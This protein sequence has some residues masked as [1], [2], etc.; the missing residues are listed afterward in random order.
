ME[1]L[2]CID[3]L[4]GFGIPAPKNLTWM[5]AFAIE[6]VVSLDGIY[7]DFSI[8]TK[9]KNDTACK[10]VAFTQTC[11]LHQGLVEYSI[12]LTNN[13]ISLRYPH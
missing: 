2:T 12:I 3:E 4:G 11:K 6:P 1:N 5:T 10:G 7:A 8:I 9:F 13:S